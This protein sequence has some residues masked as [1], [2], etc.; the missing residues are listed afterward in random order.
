MYWG[1]VRHC[2]LGT[3]LHHTVRKWGEEGGSCHGTWLS[4]L[5]KCATSAAAPVLVVRL[6]V[7]AFPR[8]QWLEVEL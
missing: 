1:K 8:M 5:T 3:R 7:P 4:L 2:G 6:E